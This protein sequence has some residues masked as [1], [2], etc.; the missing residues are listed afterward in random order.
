LKQDPLAGLHD[1]HLP[2]PISWWPPAPGWWILLGLVLLIIAALF[3][4]WQRRKK[5]LKKPKQ[6]AQ[7]DMIE[8]GLSEL[9]VLQQQAADGNDSHVVLADLSTL[10]R[11]VAMRLNQEDASIAGL[12]GDSWLQWLDTQWDKDAFSHGAGRAVIDAPFQHHGQFDV[13]VLLQI[14]RNW[15]EAQR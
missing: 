4:W 12:S 9:D 1:I 2:E 8:Q 3:W 7:S 13:D 10:L 5:Q 15:I 11:R 14:S 6:F